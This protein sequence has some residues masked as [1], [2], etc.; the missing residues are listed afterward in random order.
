MVTIVWGVLVKI[1]IS[2]FSKKNWSER[3]KNRSRR[4]GEQGKRWRRRYQIY[5]NVLCRLCAL[6]PVASEGGRRA[7]KG[8]TGKMD[9]KRERRP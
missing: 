2:V 8:M 9:C 3:V 1:S 5:R 6:V 4:K 7:K